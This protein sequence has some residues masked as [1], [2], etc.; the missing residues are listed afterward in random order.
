MTGALL[1][2]RDKRGI[3]S[4][5]R[6]VRALRTLFAFCAKCQVRLVWLIK[7]LLCRLVI[8]QCKHNQVPETSSLS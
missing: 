6:N 1:A 3:L 8:K 5:T 7:R 4:E 2:K